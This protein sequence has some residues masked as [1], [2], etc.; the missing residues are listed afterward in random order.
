M[1]SACGFI[2]HKRTALDLT[3][4]RLF[5]LLLQQATDCSLLYPVLILS[6]GKSYVLEHANKEINPRI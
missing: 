6:V 3:C 2:H 5:S 4:T 1:T